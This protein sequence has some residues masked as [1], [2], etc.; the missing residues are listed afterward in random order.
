MIRTEV[1]SS[2]SVVSVI[3]R[4]RMKLVPALR[5]AM[6]QHSRMKLVLA[7]TAVM[8]LSRDKFSVNNL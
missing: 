5:A 7:L 1:V 3:H 4:S 2:L 8:L 6:M